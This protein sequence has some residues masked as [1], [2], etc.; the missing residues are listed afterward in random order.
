MGALDFLSLP[1]QWGL[2]LDRA[3]SKSVKL[4]R[5]VISVGNIASGGRAKTPLV[6]DLAKE[7]KQRQATPVVLTRGYGRKRKQAVWLDP[8]SEVRDL[9]A[10]DSGDEALEIYLKAK[11]YVLVGADRVRN[12]QSFLKRYP[13]LPH[14]VFLLDDGFQHWRLQRDVDIVLY[15]D[16]DLADSVLPVGRLRETK[17][18][19]E[20]ATNCLKLG[21]DVVKK[22]YFK[23]EARD[24]ERTLVLTTRVLDEAYL[25]FIRQK[26]P[27]FEYVELADHAD[28][29]QMVDAIAEHKPEQLII[30]FKEAVKICRWKEIR[31]LLET[32]ETQETLG[33]L[34]FRVL[35]VDCELEF[36]AKKELCLS[37]FEKLY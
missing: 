32:G 31:D 20:R 3:L 4:S 10:D 30:G 28:A 26:V 29:T 16:F 11:C 24:F 12:A 34:N 5:P 25:N 36:K 33:D 18:A 1:F 37:I 27:S 19:L 35:V 9:S 14:V 15:N 6:I 7:L 17:E 13:K 22:S 21:E 8:N 23:A 2:K